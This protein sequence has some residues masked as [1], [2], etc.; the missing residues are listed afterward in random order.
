M[1]VIIKFPKFYLECGYF[2]FKRLRE[3]CL[4]NVPHKKL[5]EMYADLQD[6]LFLFGEDKK[7]YFEDFDKKINNIEKMA[8]EGS[9]KEE[10]KMLDLFSSFFWASDCEA[11]M[12]IRHAKAIWYYI[13]DDQSEFRFGYEARRDCATFQQFKQGIKDSIDANKGFE[14]Y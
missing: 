5:K 1:G 6:N 9:S 11:K 14:W 10:K 13:K 12:T 7:A 4:K 8:N 2:G 3:G